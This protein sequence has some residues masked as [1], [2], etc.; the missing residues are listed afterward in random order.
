MRVAGEFSPRLV[1]W[2]FHREGMVNRRYAT[3]KK[4]LCHPSLERL[5]YPQLPLRSISGLAER[6]D[7]G[8]RGV[9]SPVGG[10]W[11]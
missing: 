7:E 8:S 1:G 11:H 6:G 4:D 5:G 2:S 9:Q 3:E 10:Q